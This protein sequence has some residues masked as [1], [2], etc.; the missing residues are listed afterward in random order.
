MRS[1][2]P[3][4]KHTRQ[5]FYLWTKLLNKCLS[6]CVIKH[7]DHKQL[8]RKGFISLVLPHHNVSL[9]EV[10]LRTWKQELQQRLW[11]STTNWLASWLARPILLLFLL[12]HMENGSIYVNPLYSADPD[13]TTS[14]MGAA[15]A[16]FL[17]P[18]P[19]SAQHG[20]AAAER[21]KGVISEGSQ[22]TFLYNP[23]PSPRG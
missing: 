7:H 17:Q 20:L 5:A 12:F 10:R 14:V 3:G 21:K 6:Y 16:L 15:P 9:K 4:F 22:P 13:C 8:G 18:L 2:N 23:G 19:V 1:S 11:R